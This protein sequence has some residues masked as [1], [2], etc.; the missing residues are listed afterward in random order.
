VECRDNIPFPN[1]DF[2]ELFMGMVRKDPF[3]RMKI[4]EIKASR[5]YRGEK[6]NS[7]ELKNVMQKFLK[8]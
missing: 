6:L 7:E 2:K 8:K 4:S 1:P 5:W 3:G